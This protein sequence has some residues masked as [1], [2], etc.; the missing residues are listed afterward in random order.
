MAPTTSDI[1]GP[2]GPVGTLLGPTHETRPE[3]LRMAEAV[4][5]AMASRTHL[6]AEAGT[7][8]GK[9]FA[10]LVP[11]ILRCLEGDTVVIATHTIALQEQLITKDIPLL[12]KA[13][14]LEAPP[15]DLEPEDVAEDDG[16][17]SDIADPYEDIGSAA[18]DHAATPPAPKT[19]N[20]YPVRPIL[21]KGRGNYM[22]LRR[23]RLASQRQ[24]RLFSDPAA[25][26]SLHAIED[27]AYETSDGTLST[28]PQLERPGVWDKV[29]SDSGNCMGRR[30]PTYKICFYQKSRR[31]LEASN[32]LVCNHAL[33]FADLALRAQDVSILPQYQHVVLDEAHNVEDVA[34]EHFGVKLAER[35]IDFL[36]ASLH[37]PR[38]GRGQLSAIEL[39]VGD[40]A[41]IDR[42]V[43]LVKKAQDVSRAFF[44]SLVEYARTRRAA[45]REAAGERPLPGSDNTCR[46][47]EPAAVANVLTTAMR[48]LA[49]SLKGLKALCRQE[50][51]AFELN[52]T[53]LRAEMIAADCET[54]L[55][56]S[57]PG[58]AYWIELGGGIDDDDRVGQATLRVEIACAPVE[59]A[60]ILRE[61]LFRQDFSVT[62]ASATLATRTATSEESTESA[63][64]AFAHFM[65]RTGCEGA[66]AFQTGSPFDYARQMEVFIPRTL[67]AERGRSHAQALASH[68]LRH[69]EATGGG[70]FVLFTSF[71]TLNAVASELAMPL[72]QLGMPMLAQ[73][74]D[75]SRTHMLQRF[76]EDERSVLLGAAS[77]WQ[78]VDVRG[79][80]LRNVIITKLPF[81]P[82]DRPLT[83]ARLELIEQRGGNAFMED[84]L[85]RAIIKFKQGFG[86]LVRSKS[87]TGRVVV[88]DPRVLTAR[89]GRLFLAALPK[90]VRI[91]H[92]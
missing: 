22:S 70:A 72:S 46:V 68:V 76:R 15:A 57:L 8:V 41:P 47:R 53:I 26:R 64:T 62:L 61:R 10:Y 9:S 35:R 34:S 55:S 66:R 2:G 60:P 23:L 69:V 18:D 54:L 50:A 11:A 33:F 45:E 87:D 17:A 13:M 3:Q 21:V 1:L 5:S 6:V 36:L 71:A 31:R 49:M 51:D 12:M 74:R 24:E 25:R 90:G 59:V 52:A 27:W 56:Q 73:G 19:P 39:S 44:D 7:G 86:R 63:E 48:E 58:Y 77:F 83:Q 4:A 81:D 80:N 30:C 16:V 29:Q 79:R 37:H 20:P 78:G 67:G 38:T 84:S 91:T 65:S 92:E 40:R 75:G 28:L 32:L 88:L 14:G 85:P 43:L 82:P 89:Y 42:A